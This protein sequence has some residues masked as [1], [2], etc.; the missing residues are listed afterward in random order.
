[1]TTIPAALQLSDAELKLLQSLVYQECGMYF[2]ERRFHFLQDRVLR[3]LRAC[4]VDSFYNYYRLLT[5][6]EGKHEL[7]ALLEHLTVNETSFF[8]NKPQLELFQKV[9]LEEMLRRK[10]THRD[11]SFRAWSAGCSTGQEPYTLAMVLQEEL[12]NVLQGWTFEVQATDLNEKSL[13]FAKAAHFGDY[14]IG[15]ASCRE[16]V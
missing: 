3:R 14:E 10:Q 13:H 15:R 6:R 2:D 12:Q 9:I 5:S 16:R 11:W 7:A 4:Q 1:M 8:R